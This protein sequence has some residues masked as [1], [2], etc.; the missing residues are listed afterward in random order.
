MQHDAD[1]A[2]LLRQIFQ[3][4]AVMLLTAPAHLPYDLHDA[5]LAHVK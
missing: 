3:R 2:V 1:G 4:V 5:M